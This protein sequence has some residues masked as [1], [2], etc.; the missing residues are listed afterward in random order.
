LPRQ[1][2]QGELNKINYAA[3]IC[4]YEQTLNIQTWLLKRQQLS[5][6]ISHVTCQVQNAFINKKKT[7][8]K[9]KPSSY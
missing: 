4:N 2:S 8:S 9:L 5:N 6:R 7:A 3:Y 1:I